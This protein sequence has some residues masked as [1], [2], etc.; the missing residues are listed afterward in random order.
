M[1][2]TREI[3]DL[4]DRTL[5][6]DLSIGDPTTDI[7][8]PPDLESTAVL[9]AKE[10]GILAGLDVGLEAFRRFDDRVSI[11]ALLEDGAPIRP[12]DHLGTIQGRVASLLKAE[13][14][15]IN[16]MQHMSGIATQTQRYV[17]AVEGHPVR[18]VDTR[19]TT[20]GLRFLEKYAV[21]MGGG[22]N[23]RQNLGDGILIKDNHIDALRGDGM[24]LG[25]VVKK[26]IREASHTIRVEVE[27]ETL[28]QLDEALD[29]GAGIIL[30]DNM[31]V[32]QM[33]IAVQI[34][35][36]KAF[37]EASGG[38]TLE[39]VRAVAATG[40]DIISVGALTHSVLALDIS[41][42]MLD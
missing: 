31:D 35:K 20:P 36:G 42:D 39:T 16:F 18:I 8:V 17:K 27:V 34:A 1:Q 22:Q 33:T 32:E 40:V 6:E 14:T 37:T 11:T 41:M 24:S 30:L 10:E 7:L 9:L 13:R 19:K 3:R 21:R 29:A 26:A 12:G 5:A 15:A 2:I 4:I 23:H 38:I 28:E 25:D